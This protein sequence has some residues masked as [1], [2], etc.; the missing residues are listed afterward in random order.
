MKMN[1]P[2]IKIN[3]IEYSKNKSTAIRFIEEKEEY[4]LEPEVELIETDCFKFNQKIKKFIIPSN[5]NPLVI[6]NNTFLSSNLR[7]IELPS[8]TSYIGESAFANCLFLK[9]VTL[10]SKLDRINQ[11]T[12]DNCASLE[13]I[14][15]P[16][17]IKVI[18]K[19]AFKNCTSLKEIVI[20]SSVVCIKKCAFK[21]CVNLKEITLPKGIRTIEEAFDDTIENIYIDKETLKNQ[22]TFKSIYGKKIKI[23]DLSLDE[24]LDAGK[25]LREISNIYKNEER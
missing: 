3:G 16:E 12:F 14:V 19:F 4:V 20:P 7:E 11:F 17:G 21:G 25:S 18:N 1:I 6:E 8:N 9:N 2:T 24:L 13:K 5:A 23:T 10:N 15:L 22:P